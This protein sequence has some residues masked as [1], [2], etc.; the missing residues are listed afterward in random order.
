MGVISDKLLTLLRQTDTPT[1]CNAIEVAQGI[2]GFANFT[3]Q[4]I[5]I[6]EKDAPSL[7]GYALTAKIAAMAPSEEPAEI[8]TQR[9]MDYYKYVAEGVRP[10]VIVVQDEDGPNACGAFWGEVNTTIHKGFGVEGVITNGLVRDLEDLPTGFPVIAGAVGPSHAFVHVTDFDCPVQVFGMIV[11]PHDLIHADRHGAVV[12]P[13]S[14][15]D[16]LEQAIEKLIAC[17]KLILEPASKD[18][19]DFA[20]FQ[21]AWVAFEKART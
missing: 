5:F 13:E 14:I 2:R 21:K 9:R 19:F 18:G 8:V 7:V 17:E 16:T 15:H 10:S 4:T 11:S 3:R 1:I 12:I 6:T 20:A